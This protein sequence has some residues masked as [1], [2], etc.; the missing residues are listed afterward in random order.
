MAPNKPYKLALTVALAALALVGCGKHVGVFRPAPPSRITDPVIFTDDFGSAVEF[1][2]FGGSKVDALSIDNAEK[3]GGTAALKISVPARGDASGTYAGGAFTTFKPRDLSG[4]DAL[5]F[6]AKASK[7]ASLDV[8][9]IGNVNTGT[10]KYEAK[11]SAIPVTTEWTK[12][13]V[14][15]PLGSKLTNEG[16]LFFFAEGPEGGAANTFWFDDIRFEKLGTITNPRPVIPN[17]SV[18]VDVGS[19][20]VVPGTQVTFGV[21]GKDQTIACSQNYFSFI[22][23]NDTVATSTN[24]EM[25]AVGLGTAIITATLGSVPATGSINLTTTTAPNSAP[26]APSL[27]ASKVISLYSGAYTSVP[28]DTW[29]ASWDQADVSDVQIQGNDVKKYQNLVYAGIE[30]TTHV[31]DAGAMTHLH[32]DVWLPKGTYVKIKLVDF[33]PNGAFGGSDDSEHEITLSASSAPPLAIGS[34]ASLDIPLA[35]FQSLHA[36]AHLAQLIL[37]SDSPTLYLDNLYFHK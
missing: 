22:S 3:H 32:V 20:L 26:A 10:S 16:G 5:T 30:F 4:Y 23:S 18:S 31:I 24:G 21:D 33:G 25:K 17:L 2:A 6:W 29:S 28:V 12:F 11:R 14:A 35:D 1:Q 37:S 36:T 34:W 19:A 9:G 13:V 27:P 7:A 15:I 8:A